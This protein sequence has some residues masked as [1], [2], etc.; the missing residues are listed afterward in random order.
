MKK[1]KFGWVLALIALVAVACEKN[2]EY[3]YHFNNETSQEIKVIEYRDSIGASSY[4]L[5]PNDENISTSG[6]CFRGAT[7][8]RMNNVDSLKMIFANER[9]LTFYNT[10][11]GSVDSIGQPTTV[12]HDAYYAQGV[13][14][15]ST[16][17]ID[18]ILFQENWEVKYTLG[19]CRVTDFDFNITQKFIEQA[20]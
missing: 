12:G 20:H 8:F 16:R 14:G 15:L 11:L 19:K 18:N 7:Q 6:V 4:T 1:T 3:I 5:A 10:T 2:E 13:Q 9:V 17:G